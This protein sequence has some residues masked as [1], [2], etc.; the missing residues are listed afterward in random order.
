MWLSEL[1]VKNFRCLVDVRAEFDPVCN[2]VVGKNGAGKTSLLEAIY[3]LSRG[4]SFRN[5][6]KG[7]LT[8]PSGSDFTV[9]GRVNRDAGGHSTI[10]VGWSGTKVEIKVGGERA[11]SASQLAKEIQLVLLTPESHRLLEGGPTQRRRL[12]DWVMFHVEHRNLELL[13]SFHRT[14]RQRNALLRG[15]GDPRAL[16]AWDRALVRDAEQLENWRRQYAND[17]NSTFSTITRSLL[18]SELALDWVRG[19]PD[20]EDLL[21]CLER[22]IRPDRERGYTFHGPQR[23]NI[24]VLDRGR[25]IESQLSR[26]QSK[27]VV[28]AWLLS[29][30]AYV[31]ER[32]GV[33]GML[34]IDDLASELDRQHRDELMRYAIGLGSQL[35]ITATEVGALDLDI[36]RPGRVFHVEQGRI[37]PSPA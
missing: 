7:A 20:G 36:L 10:G 13:K 14:L 21:G 19:W 8:G 30:L 12:M 2:V 29:N 15:A 6:R 5:R 18:G 27:L 24:R 33:K 23:D 34:L 17:I 31:S 9:F 28:A 1:A 26:G 37:E 3:I 25:S 16:G 4:Y 32:S 35:F 11:T 22:N